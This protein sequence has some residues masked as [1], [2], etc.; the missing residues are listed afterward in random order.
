MLDSW[1]LIFNIAVLL[2]AALLATR[3]KFRKLNIKRLVACYLVV[4]L[5]FV[6][7]DIWAVSKGHWSFNAAYVLDIFLLN[8]AVEEILFF[9]T[10][11]LVCLITFLAI[12][13]NSKTNISNFKINIV[14]SVIASI[15]TGFVLIGSTYSY[16]QTVGLFTLIFCVMLLYFRPATIY[17]QSFWKYQLVLLVMFIAANTFLTSLPIILYGQES[18]IGIRIITIPVEDFLYNFVL[19]SSFVLA[20]TSRHLR[21]P[22]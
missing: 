19:N 7:W 16:T 8:I 12:A 4:S 22:L 10:V 11:P 6:A 17:K 20:Y 1:Y 21:L 3:F 2:S 9:L 15:A 13:K 14:I 5:P 18:I